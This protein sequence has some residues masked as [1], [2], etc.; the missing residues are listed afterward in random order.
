MYQCE[1]PTVLEISPILLNNPVDQMKNHHRNLNIFL[2][3]HI[4]NTRYQNVQAAFK[5]VLQG[6]FIGLNAFTR[7]VEKLN[8]PS[9]HFKK[10][11]YNRKLEGHREGK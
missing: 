3:E 10:Q 7:E 9:I 2:I 8:D 6:K 5:A 4:E 11:K 1:N